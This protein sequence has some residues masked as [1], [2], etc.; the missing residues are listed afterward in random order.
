MSI[1]SALLVLFLMWCAFCTEVSVD[2]SPYHDSD[3]QSIVFRY[4]FYD[5][6]SGFVNRGIVDSRANCFA[7]AITDVDSTR[8][9]HPCN[10]GGVP[11]QPL[12]AVRPISIFW[13]P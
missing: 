4:Q 7:V 9:H 2:P 5:N 3:I 8:S 11:P 13:N 10:C 12:E 1:R 6:G